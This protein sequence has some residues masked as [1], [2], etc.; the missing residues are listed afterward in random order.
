M[1]ILQF[2]LQKGDSLATSCN[3]F[4]SFPITAKSNGNVRSTIQAIRNKVSE[5]GIKTNKAEISLSLVG[6]FQS[7]RLFRVCGEKCTAT[8]SRVA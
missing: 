7:T 2:Q 8:I 6:S 4:G 3:L 1:T 5:Q